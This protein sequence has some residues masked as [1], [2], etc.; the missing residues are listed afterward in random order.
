M[1]QNWGRGSKGD[2]CRAQGSR[3]TG[4][5]H[6]QLILPH[7]WHLPKSPFPLKV[8]EG[9]GA[10]PAAGRPAQHLLVTVPSAHP[11]DG[12]CLLRTILFTNLFEGIQ[13]RTLCCMIPKRSNE[14]PTVSKYWIQCLKACCRM[15]LGCM[16]HFCWI[17]V[18][19]QHLKGSKHSNCT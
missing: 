19:Y 3:G 7:T 5:V 12:D 6:C 18:I 16:T 15:F 4:P 14:I 10:E 1:V 17:C 9:T 8:E 11:E 13:W 2:L